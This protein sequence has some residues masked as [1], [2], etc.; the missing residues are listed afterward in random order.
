MMGGLQSLETYL[1]GL[2]FTLTGHA[3]LGKLFKCLKCVC[4]RWTCEVNDCVKAPSTVPGSWYLLGLF[5]NS[6]SMKYPHSI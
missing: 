3:R 6:L 5:P 2:E 4:C 1:L